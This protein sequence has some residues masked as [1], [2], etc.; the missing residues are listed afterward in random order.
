M[1]GPVY[2]PPESGSQPLA[3]TKPFV[4]FGA[5]VGLFLLTGP[6]Q[7]LIGTVVGMLGAFAE[8]ERTGEGDPSELA[9]HI[10]VALLTTLWGWLFSL[11]GMGIILTY[12]MKKLLMRSWFFWWTVVISS[13]ALI[14]FPLGT[15]SG[16]ILLWIFVRNR[17]DYLGLVESKQGEQAVPPKSDRAG[18]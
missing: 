3:R 15:I 17:R 6:I 16:G 1:T 2:A 13:L 18:G 14:F 8:L 4:L 5:V 7:G 12:H 11:L 9:S 10:S